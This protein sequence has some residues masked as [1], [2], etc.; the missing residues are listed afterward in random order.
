MVKYAYL[1]K[2]E[3]IRLYSKYIADEKY[4]WYAAYSYMDF[5][6]EVHQT[7]WSMYQRVSV[8]K[9]RKVIGYLAAEINRATRVV[10]SIR[11]MNFTKSNKYT[12]GRDIINFFKI[13]LRDKCAVI[14]Y[15]TVVGNPI[16]ETYDRITERFGGRIVGTFL[17]HTVLRDQKY[18]D[19]KYYQILPD[20]KILKKLKL[21]NI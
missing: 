2:E 4:N 21:E 9:K 10:D 20:N 12:F 18:Y 19:R 13:L 11:I 3:L 7:E 14:T 15:S 6:L 16:E 5:Q 1:Y 17:R 8:N